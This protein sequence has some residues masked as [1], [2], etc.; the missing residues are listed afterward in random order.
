MF[1][2]IDDHP[3]LLTWITV[4]SVVMFIATLVVVPMIIARLPADHFQRHMREDHKPPPERYAGPLLIWLIFKNVLGVM[5]LIAGIAM[6]VLPGQG[7]LTMLIGMSLLNFPGKY[8]MERAL[9]RRRRVLRSLNWIR[10]RFHRE[11][12]VIEDV[13]VEH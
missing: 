13:D 5:F 7:V 8:G 9:V 1:Q 3:E 11:P 12:F 4:G 6:L 2:W 10:R